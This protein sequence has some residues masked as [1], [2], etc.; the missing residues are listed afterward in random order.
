MVGQ[1]PKEGYNLKQMLEILTAQGVEVKLRKT[2]PDARG[3]SE[4][5]LVNGVANNE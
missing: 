5:A 4:L 2:S 3:T 1:T